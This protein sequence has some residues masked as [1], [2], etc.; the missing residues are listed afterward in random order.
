MGDRLYL[1]KD[2]QV[3]AFRTLRARPGNQTC[4]DC[5]ARNPTW[6]SVTFGVF[7]CLDCSGT[8]RKLGVHISFVR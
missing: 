5:S 3:A 8:H 6:A 1:S 7:I 4:A 2:E